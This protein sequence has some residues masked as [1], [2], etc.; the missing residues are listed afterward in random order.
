M[1][2]GDVIKELRKQHKLTQSELA[3]KLG[4]AP[5]AVSAWEG[6]KNRPL[7]DKI[8]ILADLFG[9]PITR[10]FEG[11]DF[12]QPINELVML[13]IVGRISFDSG[14]FT[15]EGI[16]GYEPTPREWTIDGDFFYLRAKGDSMNGARIHEGDLL[17]I[18]K[19]IEVEDGKIAAVLVNNEV[20]LKR[21]YRREGTI[22]LQSENSLYPP[23]ICNPDDNIAIIG[24]LEKSI[25]KF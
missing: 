21:I 3:K 13:P 7:M 14:D 4:V 11:T 2:V 9:V 20:V 5:T 8:A 18:R 15:L 24:R 23:I 12:I 22:I 6:N 19:Q 25:V 1:N 10:F 16:E 17:L